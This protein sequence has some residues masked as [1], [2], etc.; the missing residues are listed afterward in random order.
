MI[1]TELQRNI[2]QDQYSID[3]TN[4][5]ND[6]SILGS[7]SRTGVYVQDEWHI[8]GAL[9]AISGLRFDRDQIKT[10]KGDQTTWKASPRVGLDLDGCAS[11]N[12]ESPVWPRLSRPERFRA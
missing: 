8:T 3:L 6:I 10:W 12:A 4:P 5:A 9:S 7:G 11:D 2:H 1:G